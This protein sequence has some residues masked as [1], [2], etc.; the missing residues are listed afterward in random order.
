MSK[1]VECTLEKHIFPKFSKY[2]DQ[3][4]PKN[5]RDHYFVS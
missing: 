3:K 2:F 1:I 4:W 5:E